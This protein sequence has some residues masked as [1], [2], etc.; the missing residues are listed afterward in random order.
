MQ[1]FKHIEKYKDLQGGRPLLDANADPLLELPYHPSVCPFAYPSS[2]LQV[3]MAGATLSLAH[4]NSTKGQDILAAG[5]ENFTHP[6]HPPLPG[7]TLAFPS[8]TS[9]TQLCAQL[10]IIRHRSHHP[11]R[12]QPGIPWVRLGNSFRSSKLHGKGAFCVHRTLS[13]RTTQVFTST[14][15]Y[16][17]RHSDSRHPA[18]QGKPFQ[19]PEGPLGPSSSS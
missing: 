3:L 8:Q 2:H 6:Q 19:C 16:V 17:P 10:T 11:D 15:L 1:C 18:P 9:S 14:R 12:N 7:W 4:L 5:R 13:M